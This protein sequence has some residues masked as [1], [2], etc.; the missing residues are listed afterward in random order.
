MANK[1]S[2]IHS[3]AATAKDKILGPTCQHF[4]RARYSSTSRWSS[5]ARLEYPEPLAPSGD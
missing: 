3:K 5:F 1:D 2:C 4:S